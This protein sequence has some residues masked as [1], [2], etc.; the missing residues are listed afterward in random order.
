MSNLPIASSPNQEQAY[1]RQHLPQLPLL[2]LPTDRS[3]RT[4]TEQQNWASLAFTLPEQLLETM[5]VLSQREQV[6]LFTIVLAAFQLLLARYSEQKDIAVQV[7]GREERL[8]FVVRTNLDESLTVRELLEQV[9]AAMAEAHAHAVP[10][11][12][13]YEFPLQAALHYHTD[14]EAHQIPHGSPEA[15]AAML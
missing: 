9:N 3:F 4:E 12:S 5:M 15:E 11:V 6:T 1:W 2:T 7:S 13:L 14:T 8:M 10:A